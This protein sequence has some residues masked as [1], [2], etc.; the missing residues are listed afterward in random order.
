VSQ[1]AVKFWLHRCRQGTPPSAGSP[2]AALIWQDE[3]LKRLRYERDLLH[4]AYAAMR[5]K[6]RRIAAHHPDPAA[7]GAAMAIL[8]EVKE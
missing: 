4:E 6:A 1:A 7:V 8:S 3:E 2:C 5:I